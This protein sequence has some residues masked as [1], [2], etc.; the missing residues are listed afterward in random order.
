MP[1][2]EAIWL[3]ESWERSQMQNVDPSIAG[4]AIIEDSEFKIYREQYK[5]LFQKIIPTMDRL[6][7]WLKGTSSIVNICNPSGYVLEAKGD[8]RFLK[9]MQAIHVHRG[10]CWSEQVQGTNSVGTVIIEKKPLVVVG[11]EHY[12]ERN[13]RLYCAASPIFDSSGKLCAVLNIS[14]HYKNYHPHILG[15]VDVAAREIEDR[16]LIEDSNNHL[17]ISLNSEDNLYRQ[18]LLAVDDDGVLT[19]VNR[20]A[21]EIIDIDHQ[22]LGNIHLSEIF[23]NVKPLLKRS[24]I[25]SS[26]NFLSLKSKRNN[27]LI[28]KSQILYDKRKYIS[29]KSQQT[30][31]K[32]L[33]GNQSSLCRFDQIFGC[34]QKFNAAIELAKKAASTDYTI[35]VT[36]ESGTGKDLV[37]QAIHHSSDRSHQP[38][39][40]VNCG[41][42]TN[43]L[44][45]SELFGY[46]AGAFTGAKQ[47]G[48][49]GKFEMAEGGTLFLDEI[50]EMPPEMQVVLLRVLNDNTITRV[51]GTKPLQLDIRIIAATNEDLWEKVQEGSFRADLFYRL[52]NLHINLPPLRERTDKLNI[53]EFLLEIIQ[54][55]LN[56]K[57]LNLSTDTKQL[58]SSYD[59]PGN[60]RQLIGA[61]RQAAF[62]TETRHIEPTHF[63]HYILTDLNQKKTISSLKESELQTINETLKKTEG[64][65]SQTARILGI[66][67]TTLYRKL[68]NLN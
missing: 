32:H 66:G 7:R 24:S 23:S 19:G 43:S 58:I 57:I 18:A 16:I 20:E 33:Q 6:A 60:V 8:V 29:G 54:K 38:F 3:K 59:W 11:K 52:Q 39:I 62:L 15:I 37:S 44:L 42:I 63:P 28:W 27:Q 49:P 17:I 48:K 5:T 35:L 13:H 64:N 45:E 41:A 30:S 10:A 65:I 2:N 21:K 50:S 56:K 55:E 14:G 36:G 68:K 67:R 25:L 1:Q 53:A 34:D 9:D 47:S 51:G 26:H 40:A 31:K 4:E 12:L 61:L 22:S 46:E